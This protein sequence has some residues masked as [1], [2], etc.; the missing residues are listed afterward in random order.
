MLFV[1][2]FCKGSAFMLGGQEMRW[3]LLVLLSVKRLPKGM[4]GIVFV[5]SWAVW[6]TKKGMNDSL[7]IP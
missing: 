3:F 7:S 6:C 5:Q 1:V 4:D 2:L